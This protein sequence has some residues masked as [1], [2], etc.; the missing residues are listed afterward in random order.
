MSD[1]FPRFA[2]LPVRPGA[3]AGSSWGVFGDRDEIGTLNFVGPEQALA[4]ARL[5]RTGKVFSLNWDLSLP[6][7]PFFGRAN[8][9]HTVFPKHD[10]WAADDY[11]D[12][13]WPQCSSQWDGLRHF[14]DPG[15]GFYNGVTLEEA[16]TD[17]QGRLGMEHWARRGIAA[18]GVLL[19]VAR[20]VED[21][22]RPLDPFDFFPIGPDLLERIAE[23]SGARL[24]PGDVLLFRTGWIEAYEKL[25]QR[26]R[27]ELAAQGRPGCP[28]L[29]G[30]DVPAWLWD[31][32][33]AAVASDNPG[34]EAG[35][36]RKGSDLRLHKALIARLGMP[37]GEFW[38]LDALAADCVEDGVREFLLTS[39][40]LNLA[41]G[42]GS[43]PNAL[44]LK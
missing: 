24:G 19:D 37:L 12:S 38:E 9:R 43:P 22:G 14:A 21:E 39:A 17:G 23:H 15:H 8:L 41:G 35:H 32:R 13:F 16:T 20:F 28:G 6:S 34:L 42:V 25:G 36:P 10:G 3:P 44:A 18:R 7:P 2:E 27:E 29:Y 1:G 33:I 11:L 26:E 40:P 5:V 30:D 4:A 31:N